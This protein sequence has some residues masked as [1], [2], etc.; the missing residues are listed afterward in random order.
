[1]LVMKSATASSLASQCVPGSVAGLTPGD[2]IR[3]QGFDNVGNIKT[4]NDLARPQ[5]NQNFNYDNLDRL[6]LGNVGG[7]GYN[8]TYD[9]NGNRTSEN[10]GS[11]TTLYN[12]AATNNRL[13]KT[14]GSNAQTYSHDPAGNR[15]NDNNG[16]VNTY[17][18]AG[19]ISQVTRSGTTTQYNYN[20]L[21]QRTQKTSSNGV[22]RLY[23]Q[24]KSAG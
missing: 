2:T 14:T 7:I 22:T 20:A 8:Y 18:D 11:S 10:H 5:L 17:N 6:T 4:I 15:L 3:S 24:L 23:D 9:D 19:R 1:M 12:H 13:N 21:G 16:L